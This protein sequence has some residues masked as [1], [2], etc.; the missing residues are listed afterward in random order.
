[1]A[2]VNSVQQQSHPHTHTHPPTT[3]K[4]SPN[5]LPAT[6]TTAAASAPTQGRIIRG[7]DH[8][9][10]FHPGPGNSPA[11]S[12]DPSS[13]SVGSNR[14]YGYSGHS[15]SRPA[16][17]Y[18]SSTASYPHNSVHGY[19]TPQVEHYGAAREVRHSSSYSAGGGGG[20][21]TPPKSFHTN[22]QHGHSG[23]KVFRP[24]GKQKRNNHNN[25]NGGSNAGHNTVNGGAS[26]P[27][28]GNHRRDSSQTNSV[29]R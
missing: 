14:S 5:S 3:H 23:S 8:H 24:R 7:R 4:P 19:P 15:S 22:S 17:A 12:R 9:K 11:R 27:S 20:G 29:N 2:A 25:N 28:H 26:H 1:M 18:G 13:S 16:S 10:A 21:P 6:T